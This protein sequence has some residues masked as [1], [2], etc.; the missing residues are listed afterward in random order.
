MYH[1]ITYYYPTNVIAPLLICYLTNFYFSDLWYPVP[2]AILVIIVR[3]WVEKKI[4]KPIGIIFSSEATPF[5]ILYV[6]RRS[7]T[8]C[9]SCIKIK[10]HLFSKGFEISL[11][12]SLYLHLF[13]NQPFILTERIYFRIQTDRHS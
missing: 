8:L 4:F 5:F 2:L 1:L 11:T 3:S 13:S 10:K 6:R 9:H 7:V 12:F